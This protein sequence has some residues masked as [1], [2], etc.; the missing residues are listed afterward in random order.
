MDVN[1]LEKA[2]VVEIQVVKDGVVARLGIV[3]TTQVV[4]GVGVT[5]PDGAVATT[6]GG[7]TVTTT[8]VG[9]VDGQEAGTLETT[10]DGTPTTTPGGA[11]AAAPRVVVERGDV[12]RALEGVALTDRS[13]SEHDDDGLRVFED[14]FEVG[15]IHR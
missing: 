8:R 13:R 1:M 4:T 9:V 14:E 5:I 12:E 11:A 3:A 7:A 10:Q 15:K 6:R 2:A